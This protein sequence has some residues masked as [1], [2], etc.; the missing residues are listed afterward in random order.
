MDTPTYMVHQDNESLSWVC[1]DCGMPQFW[2]MSSSLFRD[3]ELPDKTRSSC[4][5]SSC[6]PSSSPE[7]M[8][9]PR[10]RSTPTRQNT[11]SAP[12]RGQKNELT[13]I[14]ANCNSVKGKG[15]IIETM[16]DSLNPD[17][18]IGVETKLENNIKDNEF[19]PSTYI[20][21]RKD[22]NANGGG[23][24]IAVKQDYI[25]EPIITSSNCETVWVKLI[26]TSGK[27]LIIG[28]FYRPPSSTIEALQQ[29]D[30]DVT[31]LKQRYPNATLLIGGDYNLPHINWE[32]QAHIIGSPNK[33]HCDF[34]LDMMTNHA[35]G[36]VNRDPTRGAS[37][38][39][40]CLTSEPETV[41][42]CTTG[43]GISDHDSLLIV[44]SQHRPLQNKKKPRRVHLYKKANWDGIKDHLRDSWDIFYQNSPDESSIEDIWS[45]FKNIIHEAIELHVPSKE[46]SGK[47]RPPWITTEV[48]RLI[49]RKQ[50]IYNK[51]KKYNRPADWEKFRET[52][53]IVQNKT[54]AAHSDYVNQLIGT[55]DGDPKCI[56]RYLK[57]LRKDNCG[58]GTLVSNG[59]AATTAQDKANMLN[60]QF[61]SVFTKEDM[62]TQPPL[63]RKNHP[64]MP[65]IRVTAKGVFKL[66]SQLNPRKASGGDGIPA[67]FLKKCAEE[68][69]HPLAFVIQLSINQRQVPEDWR[70]ATVTPVYKKGPK[71]I[72][73]NYRPVSLTSICCKISEHIIV[74]QTMQH[75]ESHGL[76]S[77]FQHGFRRRRSCETQ[78]LITTH[79]L[80]KAMNDKSQIDLAVLDFEKAFDKVAHNRLI[81]KLHHL[82]LDQD[83]IGWITSFLAGRSQRVVV[84]GFSSEQAPVTDLRGTTG[85]SCRPHV[86][87]YLY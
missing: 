36:Q 54:R 65:P 24:F 80:A 6:S 82:N 28:A 44:R 39:E 74:S 84:D 27:V 87:S 64:H 32:T 70:E 76:L 2:N 85:D 11:T 53:K 71:T 73:A 62:S 14:I 77:I 7:A 43:P 46:I 31:L 60:R 50:R 69:C 37:I 22:R 58:V 12:A 1:C 49:R 66:L 78:L 18:F 61:Q 34:L 8:P 48:S 55:G 41:I 79:D 15:A 42:N 83:V 40:L 30:N 63:P 5:L 16:L 13:T 86:I 47:Y 35:L 67:A 29:L 9:S 59:I 4:T 25:M 19:M 56:W 21:V 20:T 10:A 81:R 3:G 57:G 51:A 33:Q 38:L 75:L 23:V 72:P 17:I 52:R 26:L 45:T 68:L